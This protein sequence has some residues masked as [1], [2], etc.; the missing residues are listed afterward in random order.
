MLKIVNHLG[1]IFNE[2][3]GGESATEEKGLKIWTPNQK[4]SRFPISL[5]QLKAGNNSAKNLKTKLGN[6][7]IL[8]ADQKNLQKMSIIIWSALFKNENNLYEHWNQ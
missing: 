5:V 6:Y 7:Y 2:P 8:C 3:T 1:E 4:L